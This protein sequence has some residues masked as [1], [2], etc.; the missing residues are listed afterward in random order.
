MPRSTTPTAGGQQLCKVSKKRRFRAVRPRN[1]STS[2]KSRQEAIKMVAQD[3]V[4]L[5][6]KCGVRPRGP[7]MRIR[8]QYSS[9]FRLT[10]GF[11]LLVVATAASADK[12]PIV[13]D[14][15]FQPLSAQVK[16]VVE[17]LELLGQP[18]PR[19]KTALEKAVD[20]TGGTPAIKAIQEIL[21]RHVLV[22]VE[23][24]AESRVKADA[25]RRHCPASFKTAGRS[26][27]SKSTTR[28]A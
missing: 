17:T 22:G 10:M 19:E 23:I 13:T 28:P 7:T 14:V 8:L 6:T 15:E 2:L 26:S 4:V 21:D 12:L 3:R 9:L 24:N 18:L 5:L 11:V 20:S 16:R 25:R 27:W 1:P